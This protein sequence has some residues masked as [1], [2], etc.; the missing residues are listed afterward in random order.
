M[1]DDEQRL[2]KI[3]KQH[4]QLLNDSRR[5]VEYQMQQL[6]DNSQYQLRGVFSEAFRQWKEGGCIGKES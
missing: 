6:E 3:E 4:K 5:W 2:L 1:E